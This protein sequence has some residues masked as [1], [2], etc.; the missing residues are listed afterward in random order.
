M[1]T[2][3]ELE[4]RTF[5]NLHLKYIKM[6]RYELNHRDKSGDYDGSKADMCLEKISELLDEHDNEV[7]RT[8]FKK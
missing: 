6:I 1:S 3:D 4:L 5:R 7:G 8:K 2:A